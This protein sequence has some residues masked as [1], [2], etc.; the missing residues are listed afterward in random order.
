MPSVLDS[1]R[2][3]PDHFGQPAAGGR[4]G[5]IR[6][7]E[8]TESSNAPVTD[9]SPSQLSY[10]GIRA[11]VLGAGGFIG[12]WVARSLC[13]QDASLFLFVRDAE[14]AKRIFSIFGIRGA[15]VEFDL[16][17]LEDLR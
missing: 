10:R 9:Y 4:A 14:R 5:L 12:R 3:E 2:S 1:L 6:E 13:E 7:T 11:V 8:Q 16:K 15:V 17:R